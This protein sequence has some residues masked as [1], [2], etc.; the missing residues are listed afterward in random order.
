MNSSTPQFTGHA[1]ATDPKAGRSLW[2]W[3]GAGF[4]FL[5]L[6]WAALITASRQI[7]T[8]EVPLATKE[9]KP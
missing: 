3:V 2:L 6:L 8:R 4:L 9:A 7:D 1:K 5:A